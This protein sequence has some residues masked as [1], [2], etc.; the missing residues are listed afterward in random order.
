MLG[1]SIDNGHVGVFH[2]DGIYLVSARA[3]RDGR[4]YQLPS[5]PGNPPPKYPIG[6]PLVLS[7]A[8]R[9]LG[10]SDDLGREIVVARVV[11]LTSGLL[12]FVSLFGWMR[13]MKVPRG[14]ASVIVLATAF[15]PATLVGCA[16]AIFADLTFCA[17]TYSVLF[18]VALSRNRQGPIGQGA[19]LV[20]GVI[21]SLGYLVRGNGISL[22]AAS[23][24]GAIRRPVRG[25]PVASCLAGMLL[26]VAA[27]R[28][29][30]VAPVGAVPSGDYALEFRAGWSSSRAGLAIVGANLK[31]VCIDFPTRVLFPATTYTRPIVQLFDRHPQAAL[32]LRLGVS[33]IVL[34]GLIRLARRSRHA[35]LPVWCHAVVTTGLFL[36]WPWTMILDRFLLSLFPLVFLAFAIGLS[37]VGIPSRPTFLVVLTVAVAISGVTARAIWGFH[38]NARQWPGASDRRSLSEALRLISTRLEPDAVI[39]AR[40]PDTVFLYTGRQAVPLTEDDQIL[41]GRFDE[42]ERLRLWMDQV[43]RQPFYL[44]IRS[45]K[46]DPSEADRRQA[47]ALGRSPG[48]HLEPVATTSDGRY[49]LI[50]VIVRGSD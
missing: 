28:C 20:S 13:A 43:P 49:E 24:V 33:S 7:L 19:N 30:P 36:I 8:L 41:L 3:L 35:E 42:S 4:G 47:E 14:L 50:R 29:I 10:N 26:T 32:G 2:D 34:I 16:S 11:V 25:W 38:S 27:A 48:V 17:I 31:A 9:G 21:A 37:S 40:W 15:H 6:F 12:A 39:A 23:L 46:E 5:R 44:L 18:W 1:L 45:P 22:M